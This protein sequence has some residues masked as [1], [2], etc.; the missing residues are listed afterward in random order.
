M[1]EK[2]EN[3][4]A[5][6]LDENDNNISF[7]SYVYDLSEVFERDSRRYNRAFLEEQEVC[8]R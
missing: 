6:V 2:N 1:S 4:S 7:D 8:V 5:I 3:M